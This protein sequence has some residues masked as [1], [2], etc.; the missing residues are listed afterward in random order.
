MILPTNPNQPA[1][2][3]STQGLHST[4]EAGLG[5][6]HLQF[7]T[8]FLSLQSSPLPCCAVTGLSRTSHYSVRL[9]TELQKLMNAG[10]DFEVF[11]SPPH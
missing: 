7:L 11:E 4:P 2:Q 10:E 3:A 6:V 8:H 5:E 9:P 1:I